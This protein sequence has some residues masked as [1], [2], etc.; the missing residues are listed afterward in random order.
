MKTAPEGKL[1][2]FRL[3]HEQYNIIKK[4][5]YKYIPSKFEKIIE[6]TKKDFLEGENITAD[7]FDKR[8]PDNY[9]S[10]KCHNCK[11]RNTAKC[12][13]CKHSTERY[14]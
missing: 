3:T 8:S 10:D 6:K 5:G 2:A 7:N 9:A 4:R 13:D 1:I 14:C 12:Y 11:H